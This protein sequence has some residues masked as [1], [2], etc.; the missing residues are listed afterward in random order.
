M[1]KFYN[2]LRPS[3]FDKF[4]IPVNKV[5][6]YNIRFSSKL[7]YSLAKARTNC[8]KCNI[9]FQGA[10]IWNSIDEISELLSTIQFKKKM[11]HNFIEKY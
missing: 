7:S 5:H 11:K 9:R 4:F 6:T 3:V 2:H 10:K 8:S 1:H